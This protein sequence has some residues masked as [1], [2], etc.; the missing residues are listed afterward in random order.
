MKPET[1]VIVFTPVAACGVRE[2]KND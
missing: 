2:K 1:K